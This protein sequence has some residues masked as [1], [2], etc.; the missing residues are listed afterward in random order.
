MGR[1]GEKKG[2][3]KDRTEASCVHISLHLDHTYKLLQKK[4]N[5][6][7]MFDAIVIIST[8]QIH[9]QVMFLKFKK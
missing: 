5:V 8:K 2:K 1:D 3:V 4:D 7:H 9:F 6:I